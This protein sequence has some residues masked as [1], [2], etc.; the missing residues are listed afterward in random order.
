LAVFSVNCNQ[1]TIIDRKNDTTRAIRHH[2]RRSSFCFGF[3]IRDAINGLI[4]VEREGQKKMV[5]GNK[6]AKI[7]TI[8]IEARKDMQE[9]FEAPV[10]L[11][12]WVKVKS[13]WADDERALR[14]L[15]YVDDL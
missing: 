3:M 1:T 15:G 14:S 13:G 11:E 4:L 10:H 6:G 7:K 2:F 9:M 8:G 12:L 5:I